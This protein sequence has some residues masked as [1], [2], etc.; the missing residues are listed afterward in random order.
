MEL[1][2]KKKQ[3]GLS[4]LLLP[5]FDVT[6]C[7][8][9][10]RCHN[11]LSHA[12]TPYPSVVTPCHVVTGYPQNYPMPGRVTRRDNVTSENYDRLKIQD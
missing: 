12:V 1:S 4:R 3:E 6:P 9:V 8:V 10:T 7:H 5:R 2:Q 11:P